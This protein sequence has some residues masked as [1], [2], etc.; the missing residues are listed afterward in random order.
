MK[1][2]ESVTLPDL[3]KAYQ[4]IFKANCETINL[5]MVVNFKDQIPFI[6]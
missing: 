6:S 5:A 2:M 3:K 4:C 1:D